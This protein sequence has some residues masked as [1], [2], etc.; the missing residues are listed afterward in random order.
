MR[1]TPKPSNTTNARPPNP[2]PL[3]DPALTGRKSALRPPLYYPAQH[4]L[5]R[6]P[7]KALV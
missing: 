3:R 6:R 1:L 5:F 2:E 4:K 7:L